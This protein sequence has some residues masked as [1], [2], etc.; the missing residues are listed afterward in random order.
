MRESFAFA[1]KTIRDNLVSVVPTIITFLLC[2][3]L[4]S[5]L[6]LISDFLVLLALPLLVL[7]F[8][9]SSTFVY[10]SLFSGESIPHGVF[11]AFPL[12][13]RRPHGG[14]YK[15]L[16]TFGFSVLSALIVNVVG[17]VSMLCVFEGMEPG[18]TGVLERALM[19]G[20]SDS[21]SVYLFSLVAALLSG[22]SFYF[23]FLFF[24]SRRHLDSLSP[25]YGGEPG[26]SVVQIPISSLIRGGDF[27]GLWFRFY[28]PLLIFVPLICIAMMLP[29]YFSGAYETSVYV[30]SGL[31][32]FAGYGSSSLLIALYQPVL[33][34]A[35][36]HY[37]NNGG[38]KRLKEI[39]DTI[40]KDGRKSFFEE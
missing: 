6:V 17:V 29:V 22:L 30:R 21:E 4:A 20:V 9:F 8:L 33:V 18:F 19:E 13:F 38:V 3:V 39:K 2:C 15:G 26:K 34:L 11:K 28:W 35:V 1:L 40:Y 5:S 12:Y 10:R 31:M 23:P 16:K 14:C 37:I 27:S 25:V 36:S 32:L 24:L 7:P